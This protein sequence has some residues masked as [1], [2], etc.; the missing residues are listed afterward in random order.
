VSDLNKYMA[1][2]VMGW[3]EEIDGL[4]DEEPR[5]LMYWWMDKSLETKDHTG[6]VMQQENWNPT[7]DMNQ[8]MMCADKCDIIYP[9]ISNVPMG[10]SIF[11]HDPDRIAVTDDV[12]EVPQAIC[13]AI[14]E[15]ICHDN[16]GE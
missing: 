13:Q 1:E 9:C 15:A 8:A 2:K 16:G 4:E 3:H 6:V 11:G 12:R 5:C 14:K 7:K 10:W